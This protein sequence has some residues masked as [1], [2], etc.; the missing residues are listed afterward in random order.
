MWRD[1]EP[2]DQ[3]DFFGINPQGLDDTALFATVFLPAGFP[4]LS[5]LR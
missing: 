4:F 3:R 1:G 2:G 5:H